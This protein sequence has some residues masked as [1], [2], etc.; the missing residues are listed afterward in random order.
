MRKM[1]AALAAAATDTARATKTA[2]G[3]PTTLQFEARPVPVRV[4][5]NIEDPEV[6]AILSK[7]YGP[8]FD[9][10]LAAMLKS[11]EVRPELTTLLIGDSMLA[12]VGSAGRDVRGISNG[13]EGAVAGADH[14]VGRL[15]KRLSR[16]FSHDSRRR[17][18]RLRWQDR[19]F[20]VAPVHRAND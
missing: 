7:A 1:G 20:N 8:R 13:T 4:R 11:G 2:A 18:R 15:C 10:Y 19:H 16:L 6:K 3:E 9:R 5:W 17:S 14:P 12:L